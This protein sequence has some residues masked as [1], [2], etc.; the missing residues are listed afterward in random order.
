MKTLMLIISLCLSVCYQSKAQLNVALLHQL[1]EHSKQEYD[2]QQTLRKTQLVASTNQ[3]INTQQTASLKSRYREITQRYGVLGTVLLTLST[4]I[5]SNQIVE[6]II[7]EQTKIFQYV[8]DDPSTIL[9]ALN[10]QREFI[11]RA[12]LLAKYILGLMLSFGDLNQM[13][14]SDRRILYAHVISELRNILSISRSL[15]NSIYYSSY[16]KKLKSQEVFS[17]F[18]NQDKRIVESILS[19]IKI[20]AP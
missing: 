10:S 11:T 9:L 8:Q 1:V 17:D 5:E 12:Q 2:K 3:E 6:Q 13:K 20:L 4:S 14:Q 16:V 18:V 15:A 7:Q 19:K